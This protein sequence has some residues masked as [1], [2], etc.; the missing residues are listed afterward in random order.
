MDNPSSPENSKGKG[1]YTKFAGIEEPI[2]NEIVN[3]AY[4]KGIVYAQRKLTKFSN[5]GLGSSVDAEDVVHI[6]MLKVVEGC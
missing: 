5:S 2:E 3:N 4:L 1:G 6:A